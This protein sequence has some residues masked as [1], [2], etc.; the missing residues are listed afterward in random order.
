MPLADAI[1]ATD[2]ALVPIPISMG[3]SR[4]LPVQSNSLSDELDENQR[5]QLQLQGYSNALCSALAESIKSFPLRFWVIDNSGSMIKSDG[6]RFVEDGNSSYIRTVPCSRWKEIQQ[7]V[8]YHV[9][10]A[11]LLKVPTTFRLL[12][13]PGARIGPQEFTIADK[14]ESMIDSD[15][16][17]ARRTIE[18]VTPGGVTPLSQHLREIQQRVFEISPALIKA[19]QKVIIVLATDGLP[20]NDYGVGGMA[21]KN[22]FKQALRLLESL[23]VWVIIRLCTDEKSVVDFYNELDQELEIELEVLDDFMSEAIEVYKNNNWLTYSLQ[24]HRF[25]E[26][27]CHIRLCDL[28]DERRLSLGEIRDFCIFLFG[29]DQFDGVPEPDV[30]IEG[31][32]KSI[33]EILQKEK[34]Q[35]NPIK[36]KPT[37]SVNVPKIRSRGQNDSCNIL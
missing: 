1:P 34:P 21:E 27:G 24:L 19:G 22:E 12:N 29:L 30:D 25:R 31:F 36:K 26:M 5:K 32:L 7:T 15:V 28:L 37:P 4:P 6:Q 33:H 20:T 3:V 9:Q 13:N 8:M 17:I 18:R 2:P 35:F 11:A 10:M 16:Q 23:P 14:G